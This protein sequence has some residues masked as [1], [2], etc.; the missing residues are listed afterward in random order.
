MQVFW[1]NHSESK[2]K[3]FQSWITFDTQLKITIIESKERCPRSITCVNS[4]SNK[5]YEYRASLPVHF[6]SSE[7]QIAKISSFQVTF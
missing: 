4:T 1:A 5:S 6:F 3:T 2:A 7:T